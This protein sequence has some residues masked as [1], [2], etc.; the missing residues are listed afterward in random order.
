MAQILHILAHKACRSAI[1]CEP[2]ASKRA[3]KEQMSAQSR[4]N[5]IQ[6]LLSA[7]TQSVI[8]LSQVV[9]QAKQAS[10]QF[11]ELFIINY[12]I[13]KAFSQ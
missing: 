11:L 3:H 1:N 6:A 13:V 5:K 4:H 2:L 7:A 12:F 9:K 10:I 8:Q